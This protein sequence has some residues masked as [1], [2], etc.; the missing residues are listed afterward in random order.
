MV[1]S[2][3]QFCHQRRAEKNK[4]SDELQ[5]TVEDY[6]QLVERQA[7]L[8]KELYNEINR[9]NEEILGLNIEARFLR[10]KIENG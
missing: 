7:R 10:G 6:Q 8:V 1:R 5:N 2:R 4:M 9:L 3:K